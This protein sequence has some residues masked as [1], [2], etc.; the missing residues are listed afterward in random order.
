MGFSKV[1]FL[2]LK[3]LAKLQSQKKLSD[4]PDAPVGHTAY[5]NK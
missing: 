3:I 5:K 1:Q 4:R 2:H